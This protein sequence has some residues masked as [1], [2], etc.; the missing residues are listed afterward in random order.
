MEGSEEGAGF[1]C[2]CGCWGWIEVRVVFLEVRGKATR[3]L[4]LTRLRDMGWSIFW[5]YLDTHAE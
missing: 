1:G 5:R 2:H 4:F 3:Q